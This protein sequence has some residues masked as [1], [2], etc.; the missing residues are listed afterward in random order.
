[1]VDIKKRDKHEKSFKNY[2]P[3]MRKRY[4]EWFKWYSKPSTKHSDDPYQDYQN[5]LDDVYD[6]EEGECS[7]R[8]EDFVVWLMVSGAVE[9]VDVARWL[10]DADKTY[11]RSREFTHPLLKQF[12]LRF[13][14]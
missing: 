6:V 9:T 14:I 2:A 4:T 1:V 5:W 7:Q 11:L 12:L 3:Y 8:L 13:H 10:K